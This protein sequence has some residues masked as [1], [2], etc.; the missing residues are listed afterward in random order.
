LT[1]V[2]AIY[3]AGLSTY[4]F[5]MNRREKR[6]VLTVKANHALAPD[7]HGNAEELIIIGVSNPGF[8]NVT[9]VSVSIEL[10]NRKQL[11][12]PNPRSDKRIPHELTPGT[13]LSVLQ[14]ART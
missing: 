2:I 1:A 7:S 11:V 6:R 3:G 12:F 10:P 9:V 14:S 5:I 4:T 8:Q 13:K